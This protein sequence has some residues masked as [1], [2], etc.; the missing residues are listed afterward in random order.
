[1]LEFRGVRA[2]Y[3]AAT[4]RLIK[5]STGGPD[6]GEWA[7]ARVHVVAIAYDAQGAPLAET[8]LGGP[9]GYEF[10][11]AILAAA[12]EAVATREPSGVGALVPV[13]ALGIEELEEFCRQV[14]AGADVRFGSAP[15]PAGRTSPTPRPSSPKTFLARLDAHTHK[16]LATLR[17]DGSPRISGIECWEIDGDLWMGSMARAVKA[18]D[19]QRDPRYALHSGSGRAGGLGGRRQAQ[20]AGRGDH[21][22]R[23]RAR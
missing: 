13:E 23:A 21:R 22:P 5:G 2:L 8:H 11:G 19:L 14:G 12:A 16:T 18:L 10:T 20:R 9:E 1:M 4:T 15:W 3:D 17:K 7:R 6:A